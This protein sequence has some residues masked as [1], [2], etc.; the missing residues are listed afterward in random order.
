MRMVA[1][2]M[3]AVPVAAGLA[4]CIAVMAHLYFLRRWLSGTRR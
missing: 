2:S 3:A 4:W 1:I